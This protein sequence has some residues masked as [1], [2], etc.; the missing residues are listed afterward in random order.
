MMNAESKGE[1]K[2]M[3]KGGNKRVV[4]ILLAAVVILAAMILLLHYRDAITIESIVN[5]TPKKTELAVLVM[6]CLF[7]VKSVSV[8]IYGGILFT[9][10]G[11]LFPLPLAIAVNIAGS[12]FMSAIPYGIGKK[13]GQEKLTALIKKYPKM[14]LLQSVPKRNG[15]LFSLILRII[16]LLPNNI[17]GIYIGS[18][19]IPFLTYISGALLGM[20][21]SVISFSVMGM[22]AADRSSPAFIISLIVELL[23]ITISVVGCYIWSRKKSRKG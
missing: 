10:S 4:R 23:L 20:L 3:K 14:A 1:E 18:T 7:L 6:L 12:F 17:L 5:F 11:I 22:S 15:F 13:A 9:A 21:P 16:G 2:R 19:G 8:F